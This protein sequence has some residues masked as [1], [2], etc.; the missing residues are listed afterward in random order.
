MRRALRVS[1]VLILAGCG[2]DPTE[3]PSETTGS[4]QGTV[5]DN[6]G[7]TVANAAV[8]LTG[9][10]QA[11]RTTNSGADGVYTFADV[12]PGTYTLAIAPPAGFTIG[13]AGTASVT[14]ASG[15]QADA[16]S[17]VLNRRGRIPVRPQD[18]GAT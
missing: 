3:V 2:G 16:S 8:A 10:A 15:A 9:N 6:T 12:P 13:V 4:I 11:G 7:A 14:V 17:I 5:T 18:M 1:A